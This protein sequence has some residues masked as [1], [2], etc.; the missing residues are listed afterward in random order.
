MNRTVQQLRERTGAGDHVTS[1]GSTSNASSAA[2]LKES[3]RRRRKD[4][5]RSGLP[6][7]DRARLAELEKEN[8]EL[9]GQLKHKAATGSVDDDNGTGA[10]DE[11]VSELQEQLSHKTR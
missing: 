8:K 1:T 4:A 2:A 3:E 5:H 10:G 9:R 6:L 11:R 7:R